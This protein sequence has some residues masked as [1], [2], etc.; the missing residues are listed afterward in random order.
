MDLG[1]FIWKMRERETKEKWF[2]IQSCLGFHFQAARKTGILSRHPNRQI[3]SITPTDCEGAAGEKNNPECKSLTQIQ[4]PNP[5]LCVCFLPLWKK[6]EPNLSPRFK[7][8]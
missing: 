7:L 8:Q 4:M 5:I 6:K 2:F 3:N 1:G